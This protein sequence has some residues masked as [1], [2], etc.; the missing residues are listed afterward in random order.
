MNR[1]ALLFQA[2]YICFS[3]F[4]F[5][6]FP[7]GGEGDHRGAWARN[8]LDI[9]SI[10]ACAQADRALTTLMGYISNPAKRYV[11]KAFKW[12]QSRLARIV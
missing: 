2:A 7:G 10:M 3:L 4:V 5:P 6:F 1:L 9:R 12:R 8:L 11:P